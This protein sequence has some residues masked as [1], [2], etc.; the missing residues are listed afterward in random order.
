[1]AERAGGD[2]T[3]CGPIACALALVAVCIGALAGHGDAGAFFG[4]FILA[5][6]KE[7]AS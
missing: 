4:V 2:M 6:T 3:R 1:M 7:S 5:S